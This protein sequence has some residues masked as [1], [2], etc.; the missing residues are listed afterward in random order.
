ML[1]ELI[2]AE[3]EAGIC[4]IISIGKDGNFF[5]SVMKVF[6]TDV[7]EIEDDPEL[8]MALSLSLAESK[9]AT[10]TSG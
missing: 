5:S 3:M 8:A 2:S 7:A 10:E 6:G 1:R 9:K 4:D